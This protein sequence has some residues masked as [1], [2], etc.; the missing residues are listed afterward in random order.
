MKKYLS[1]MVGTMVL[2]LMRC[3]SAV[4]AGGTAAQGD[5]LCS[6]SGSSSLPHLR[7]QH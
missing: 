6:S 4:M 7:E 3:G 2:V 1:E 5:R